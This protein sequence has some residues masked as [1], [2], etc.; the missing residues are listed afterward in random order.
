MNKFKRYW[1]AAVLAGGL[2]L[3]GL[4]I[5]M[6]AASG[7]IW[8]LTGKGSRRNTVEITLESPTMGSA[9]NLNPGTNNANALGTSS[10]RWSDVQT[11]DLTAA[12]DVTVTDDLTVT[13]ALTVSGTST[14]QR[15]TY[16][17][18]LSTAPRTS[19]TLVFNSTGT[20]VYNTTN[21]YLCISTGS[22]QTSFVIVSTISAN[23][24]CEN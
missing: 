8:T 20:L 11:T 5:L 1:P 23:V 21:K 18:Q 4:P 22:A 13:D 16:G 10:L 19:T 3:A 9:A 6:E 2:F 15:V 14:L 7:T 17:V 24:A 12:D